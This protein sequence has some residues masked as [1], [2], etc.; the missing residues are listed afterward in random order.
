MLLS[1]IRRGA[2]PA[3]AVLLA[4]AFILPSSALAEAVLSF[5]LGLRVEKDTNTSL[6]A[7]SKL[8]RQGAQLRF[9]MTY[10][11]ETEISTFA[12]SANGALAAYSGRGAK[13]GSGKGL[14]TPALTLAYERG[15]ADADVK[16][17]LLLSQ[18]DLNDG[19]P[20]AID[21]DD[22]GSR[23]TAKISAAANWGKTA[24]LGF[25]L[26]ASHEDTR[27][28]DAPTL[29]DRKVD[30]IGA[31]ARAQLTDVLVADL[32][33]GA[34]SYRRVGREA[35]DTYTARLGFALAHSTGEL[36]ASFGLDDAPEG[37]RLR[38]N[39]GQTIEQPLGEISW[40]LGA[41]RDS[42][43]R[44]RLMGTLNWQRE[45]ID[46][47]FGVT[48]SRDVTSS[49]VDDR[50]TLRNNLTVNWSRQLTATGGVL[51][52]ASWSESS[53]SDTG[54]EVTGT[55]LS[56][57]WRQEVTQDWGLDLGYV[58]RSRETSLTPSVSSDRIYVELRRSF[59]VKF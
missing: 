11:S 21:F 51:L 5:D 27:Y 52:N 48:Y 50:E 39:I 19:D 33:L 1:Q 55:Q 34:Q 6:T 46:G 38:F 44:V 10:L 16:L 32:S 47:A 12:L 31:S 8:P 35:R 45:L 7:R 20:G 42:Q 26:T 40:T 37:E 28:S 59:A 3:R 13:I 54:L 57:V 23:R 24:P 41:V 36:R 25:G 56:A 9:G 43:G 29:P 49:D 2:G 22:S 4:S 30:K 15:V 53:Y 14:V 17:D 18:N 58:H